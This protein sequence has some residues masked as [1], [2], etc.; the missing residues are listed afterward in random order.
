MV[1]G[2]G[3]ADPEAL[4]VEKRV[5]S[6]SQPQSIACADHLQNEKPRSLGTSG[7]ERCVR[8]GPAMTRHHVRR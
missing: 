2:V 8:A 6:G 5:G 1:A 4:Q 7:A 3:Y